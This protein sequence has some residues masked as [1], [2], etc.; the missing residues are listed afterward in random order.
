M[1]YFFSVVFLNV[2]FI[3]QK[4][5]IRSWCQNEGKI[6][7][8]ES[9]KFLEIESLMLKKIVTISNYSLYKYYDVIILTLTLILR[10][11]GDKV[12]YK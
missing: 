3:F 6:C 10:K 4:P 5:T 9:N 12:I 11:T 2:I 1:I 8:S 7:F